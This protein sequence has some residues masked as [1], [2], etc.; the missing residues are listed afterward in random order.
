MTVKILTPEGG[1][2]QYVFL[3]ALR[4]NIVGNVIFTER[5]DLEHFQEAFKP[6]ME[7]GFGMLDL[8]IDCMDDEN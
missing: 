1:K 4:N 3:I 5:K 6:L 8:H 2:E 7:L